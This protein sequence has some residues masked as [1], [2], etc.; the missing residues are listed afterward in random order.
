M[1]RNTLLLFFMAF[2]LVL[3]AQE[4]PQWK[5]AILPLVVNSEQYKKTAQNIER[6]LSRILIEGLFRE[7]SQ[8]DVDRLVEKIFQDQLLQKAKAEATARE[9]WERLKLLNIVENL[10][11]L[12]AQ[13][14]YEAA[15]LLRVQTEE[16]G[17]VAY[18]D[19]QPWAMAQWPQTGVVAD[20]PTLELK[21][22]VHQNQLSAFVTGELIELRGY[23]GIKLSVRNQE[24]SVISNWEEWMS[25]EEVPMRI[26]SLEGWLRGVLLQR[27]W[28]RLSIKVEPPTAEIWVNNQLRGLGA[29]DLGILTPGDYSITLRNEGFETY[30]EIVTIEES[31]ELSLLKTLTTLQKDFTLIQTDPEGAKVYVGGVF[32]GITPLEIPSSGDAKYLEIL[33]EGFNPITYS[34]LPGMPVQPWVLIP[35]SP[36]ASIE[37]ARGWFYFALGSFTVSFF[38]TVMFRG[39]EA[40]Y[41]QLSDAYVR[42]YLNTNVAL[43]TQEQLDK[44]HQSYTY[45]QIFQKGGYTLMGVTAVLF[46]WTIWELSRYI[47]AAEEGE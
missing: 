17:A 20:K 16:A 6:N 41:K 35:S 24:L 34:L 45:Q 26:P 8:L 1:I 2:S 13:A 38:T 33:K 32:Q 23:L 40:E 47:D 14:A 22:W 44:V 29:L 37:D 28:A 15:R 21:D 19:T 39:F 7:P 27:P 42:D 43:R 31:S 5:W 25:P 30:Q 4:K 12:K 3:N 9:Q 10:E 46:G 11:V 36:K 18:T